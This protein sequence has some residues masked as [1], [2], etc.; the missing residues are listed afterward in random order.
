MKSQGSLLHKQPTFTVVLQDQSP[1]VNVGKK[2]S[3]SELSFLSV[4]LIVHFKL[5][6]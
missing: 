5:V 3:P 1:L 4:S 2:K 6:I